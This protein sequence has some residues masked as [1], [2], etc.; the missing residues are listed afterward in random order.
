[1][2]MCVTSHFMWPWLRPR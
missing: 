2:R 1:V